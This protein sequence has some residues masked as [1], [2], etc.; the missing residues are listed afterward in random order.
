MRPKGDGQN[1]V[2]TLSD[3]ARLKGCSGSRFV[4]PLWLTGSLATYATYSAVSWGR[5]EG[6]KTVR[7]KGQEIK[8]KKKEKE[9]GR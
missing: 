9:R 4:S 7:R 3:V 6:S 2:F 8:K 5:G 1:F